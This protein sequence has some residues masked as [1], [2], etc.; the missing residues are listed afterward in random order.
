MSNNYLQKKEGFHIIFIFP[1]SSCPGFY[2][3]FLEVTEKKKDERV[4]LKTLF[5][6]VSLLLFKKISIEKNN[7][8]KND[9]DPTFDLTLRV[10]LHKTQS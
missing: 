2:S 7:Y 5:T 1:F 4:G 10:H 3:K 6:L 8:L 9:N